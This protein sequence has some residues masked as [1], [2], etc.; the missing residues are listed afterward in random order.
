MSLH[1][2]REG[3][4]MYEL[5]EYYDS[6]LEE[7]THQKANSVNALGTSTLTVDDS[8]E[9]LSSEAHSI[10]RMAVGQLQWQS[11]IRPDISY[12]F[13]ELARHLSEPTTPSCAQSTYC[14]ACAEL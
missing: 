8:V 9:P 12:I 10:Y 13:E 11:P 4:D 3:L 7:Y 5:P 14:G 2:T 6:I 1:R